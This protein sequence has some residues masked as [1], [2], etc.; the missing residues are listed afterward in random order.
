MTALG[1]AERKS[2]LVRFGAWASLVAGF[3]RIASSFIPYEAGSAVLEA[4][5]GVIDLGL[6]F[7]LIAI[8]IASAERTGFTGLAAFL[9]ALAGLA[10]I[11]GPDSMMSGVDFY[12]IGALVFVA[13]LAG[14]SVQLLRVGVMR[15]SASL[16]LLAFAAGLAASV[17]QQVF[18]VAGIALGAGFILAG[19]TLMRGDRP[20]TALAAA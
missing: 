3:L 11:V 5:Y 20:P 17:L 2:G 18:L 12:R 6:M 7:G 1:L 14:L 15:A 4:L 10:S 16:W 8:Y 19:I 9:V 13:G